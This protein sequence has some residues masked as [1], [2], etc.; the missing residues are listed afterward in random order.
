M[1]ALTLWL[2]FGAFLLFPTLDAPPVFTRTAIGL[3]ASELVT[4]A[5]WSTLPRCIAPGCDQA[6]AIAGSAAGLQ[7]PVLTGL[8]LAG[9]AFY[10]LR[11]A[12]T[13]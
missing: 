1:I 11:A 13:W 3:C 8:L 10:G 6:A 4:V 2:S 5:L 12:R 7:I 9:A